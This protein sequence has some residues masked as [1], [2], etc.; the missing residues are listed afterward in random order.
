MG[1]NMSHAFP[2]VTLCRSNAVN[3]SNTYQYKKE[4]HIKQR[5]GGYKRNKLH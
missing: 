5:V 1:S 4:G 2:A 3:L